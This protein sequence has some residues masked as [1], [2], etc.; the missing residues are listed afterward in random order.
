MSCAYG[1]PWMTSGVHA[2]A[3]CPPCHLRSCDTTRSCG[4]SSAHK[5]WRRTLRSN[6]ELRAWLAECMTARAAA[7]AAPPR[8]SRTTDHRAKTFTW[9]AMELSSLIIIASLSFNKLRRLT[10]HLLASSVVQVPLAPRR[11]SYCVDE[12]AGAQARLLLRDAER[13]RQPNDVAVRRLRE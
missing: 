6:L 8:C 1:S 13:R 12:N 3:S 11:R 9:A 2:R 7:A 10:F 5:R 4:R